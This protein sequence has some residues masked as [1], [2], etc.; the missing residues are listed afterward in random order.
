MNNIINNKKHP[1]WQRAFKSLLLSKIIKLH[2]T[3]EST[4]KSCYYWIIGWVVLINRL[5]WSYI[6]FFYYDKIVDATFTWLNNLFFTNHCHHVMDK[7]MVQS[8]AV[9]FLWIVCKQITKDTTVQWLNVL[10]W[11]VLW[12]LPSLLCVIMKMFLFSVFIVWL[13]KKKVKMIQIHSAM[14]IYQM[15]YYINKT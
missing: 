2:L 3:T 8:T 6:E 14:M 11:V 12:S 13:F 10:I 5:Q 7:I 9:V 4:D 1:I 15:S